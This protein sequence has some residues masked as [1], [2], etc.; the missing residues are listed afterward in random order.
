ME[1]I[2]TLMTKPIYKPP[3]I[4]RTIKQQYIETTMTV[5]DKTT[6]GKSLSCKGRS[7]YYRRFDDQVRKWARRFS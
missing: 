7:F 5:L 4:E 6:V 2:L 3:L 1:L